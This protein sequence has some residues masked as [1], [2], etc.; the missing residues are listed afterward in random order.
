MPRTPTVSLIR[1][2]QTVARRSRAYDERHRSEPPARLGYISPNACP[3]DRIAG[4]TTT[5][6][7]A[8]RMHTTTGNTI[9]TGRL[10]RLLLGVLAASHAHLAGL[11][12][13]DGAD[14]DAEHVGLDHR[15]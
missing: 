6:I 2:R 1:A 3:I 12:P 13:E 14:A 7:V 10:L 8:G 4:P 15:P 11:A 9:F 5:S